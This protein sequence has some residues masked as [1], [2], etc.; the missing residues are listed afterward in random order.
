MQTDVGEN[1]GEGSVNA[2]EGSVNAV[3]GNKVFINVSL[4]PYNLCF[5]S[6]TSQLASSL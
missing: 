4:V 2:G 3:K 1:A 6:R 5:I